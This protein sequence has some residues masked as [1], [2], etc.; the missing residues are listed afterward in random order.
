MIV[1]FCDYSNSWG[2][3]CCPAERLKQTCDCDGFTLQRVLFLMTVISPLLVM[4]HSK[5]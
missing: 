2:Q 1:C 5:L 3:Y 4:A